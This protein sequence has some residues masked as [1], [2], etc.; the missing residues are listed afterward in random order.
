MPWLTERKRES[1]M[2]DDNYFSQRMRKHISQCMKPV[3]TC[4]NIKDSFYCSFD[5]STILDGILIE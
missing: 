5:W 3:S 2:N 4:K 1:E